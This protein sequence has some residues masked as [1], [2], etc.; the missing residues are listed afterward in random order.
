MPLG[1]KNWLKAVTVMEQK[2][3]SPILTCGTELS[4]QN[5]NHRESFGQRAFSSQER[6]PGPP[7]LPHRHESPPLQGTPGH[8]QPG[9]QW[10][11][12]AG[13]GLTRTCLQGTLLP[14]PPQGADSSPALAH[15]SPVTFL[16]S[17]RSPAQLSCGSFQHP[18]PVL[19]LPLP[20][21]IRICSK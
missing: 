11:A 8:L 12:A 3:S 10:A 7:P 18:R 4:C 13:P 16:Q 19:V 1:N 15:F 5:K 9:E 20:A 17:Q 14:P 2:S 6:T 21:L